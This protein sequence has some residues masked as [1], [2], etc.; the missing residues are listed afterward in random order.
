[1]YGIR[2]GTKHNKHERK[3]YCSSEKDI[4]KYKLS[5][6]FWLQGFRG[7]FEGWARKPVYHTIWVAVGTA[8]DRPKSICN[9]CGVVCVVTLPFDMSACVGAFVIRLS[10][11][12]SFFFT[13]FLLSTE[14]TFMKI[15]ST[16]ISI[17]RSYNITVASLY[18]TSV[19]WEMIVS[20]LHPK[21][22]FSSDHKSPSLSAIGKF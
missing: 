7:E 5:V 1:M 19:W 2:L 3:E 22:S 6:F 20:S 17:I 12:S 10:Q 9:R 16:K 4:C 13:K 21:I 18:F 15:L 11:I 8:T 14:K